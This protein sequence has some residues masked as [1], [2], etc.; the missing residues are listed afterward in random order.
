MAYSDGTAGVGGTA[1]AALDHSPAVR[2]GPV[3][4]LPPLPPRPL[5]PLGTVL[6][7]PAERR[8]S[9]RESTVGPSSAAPLPL[10]P[11]PPPVPAPLPVPLPAAPVPRPDA[12]RPRTLRLALPGG[13]EARRRRLLDRVRVPLRTRHRIAVLG[14]PA[15]GAAAVL[16]ALLAEHRAHPVL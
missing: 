3:A 4:L 16:G 14:G 8:P 6:I 12:D 10:L 2:P 13:G 7:P 5:D 9:T 11:P 15:E 1:P